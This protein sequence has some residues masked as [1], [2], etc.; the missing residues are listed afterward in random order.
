MSRSFLVRGNP[1]PSDRGGTR[2]WEKLNANRRIRKDLWVSSQPLDQAVD[3][4][5]RH[6]STFPLRRLL[7]TRKNP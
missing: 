5:L 1:G 4:E 7:E 3:K 6:F 2:G